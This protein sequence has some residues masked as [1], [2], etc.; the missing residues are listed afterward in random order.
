MS[1]TIIPY[2]DYVGNPFSGT[3]SSAEDITDLTTSN[4][5]VL[6]SSEVL[7]GV[8]GYQVE[9]VTFGVGASDLVA[10]ITETVSSKYNNDHVVFT[11]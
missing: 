4:E 11:T 10:D 8:A 9:Y 7:P 1:I 6:T 5:V 3:I 2:E